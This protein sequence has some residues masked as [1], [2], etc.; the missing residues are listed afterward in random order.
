MT[1]D[2]PRTLLEFERRFASELL[3]PRILQNF[4]GRTDGCVP[5]STLILPEFSQ[6]AECA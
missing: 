4:A 3:V 6:R 2:Y 1:E 5:G